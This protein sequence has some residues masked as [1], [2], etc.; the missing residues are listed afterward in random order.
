MRVIIIMKA[1]GRERERECVCV[2]ARAACERE[3]VRS[4]EKSES[5]NF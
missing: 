1:E 3:M 5:R 2:C 4:G